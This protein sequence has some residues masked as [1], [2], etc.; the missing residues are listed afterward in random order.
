MLKKIKTIFELVKFSHSIFA[1]PFALGAMLVAAQGWP[2]VKTFLLIV[3]AMVTARSAAMAFNRLVDADID[4]K[5]RR[6][7]NRH[8]PQR[9]LTKKSVALFTLACV[10]LFLVTCTFINSLSF[11]LSPFVLLFIL[12]Y[13][14]SKRFTWASHL[15]LGASLGLAPLA[16]WVAV[17][18]QWPWPALSLGAA[19]TFWVA[20]FDIIYATQDFEFDCKEKLQSIVA[21]FGLAKG[22]RISRAFHLMSVFFLFWFGFQ[23]HLGIIY[24]ATVCLIAAGLFYEQ[25]LIKPTDLSKINAAFFNMNGMISLLFLIGTLLEI[26][27]R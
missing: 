18:N 17:T 25:H 15:W 6:T 23:N 26:N 2:D 7:Q 12:G 4:A 10:I 8:I 1:L 3:A 14:F 24:G 19:V 20:G 22:L 9:L 16:A 5:N 27:A 21:R 11:I 13:S